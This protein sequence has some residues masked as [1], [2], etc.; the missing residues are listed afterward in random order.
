MECECVWEFG[1]WEAGFVRKIYIYGSQITYGECV[2]MRTIEMREISFKVDKRKHSAIRKKIKELFGNEFKVVSRGNKLSVIGDF[3]NY[4][5]RN[6]IIYL[7]SGGKI[8]EN[9]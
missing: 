6:K 7:L 5:K 3:H 1:G 2:V 4:R 8:G 9:V